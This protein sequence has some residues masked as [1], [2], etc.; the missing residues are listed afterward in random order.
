M[1][2]SLL[3]TR[4][5]FTDAFPD[6]MLSRAREAVLEGE[7]F[8]RGETTLA[9][10]AEGPERTYQWGL[11]PVGKDQKQHLDALTRRERKFMDD[12]ASRH[13]ARK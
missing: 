6:A 12:V 2:A 3:E 10:P 8:S 7:R 4:R 5:P 9:D 11:V 1:P 13:H